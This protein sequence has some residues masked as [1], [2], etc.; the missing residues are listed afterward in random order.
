M[1]PIQTNITFGL[2]S[3]GLISFGLLDILD[4]Y[5]STGHRPGSQLMSKYITI[6]REI[7]CQNCKLPIDSVPKRRLLGQQLLV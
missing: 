4:Y 3:L 2:M 6:D 1:S 5:H 7:I